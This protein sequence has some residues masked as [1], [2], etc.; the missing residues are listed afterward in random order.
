MTKPVIEHIGETNTDALTRSGQAAEHLVEN[1]AAAATKSGQTAQRIMK[2]NID[3][4]TKSGNASGAAFKEL[5]AAYQELATK[6]VK[7]LTAAMQALA[8][9]KHPAEFVTLQQR[10]IKDGVEAAVRDGQHIAQLTAAVF[11]A[12]FQPVKHRIEAVQ[13]KAVD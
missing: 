13:K 2:Y 12:A 7:N 5:T 10:L 11:T 6:N 8:T 9:V 4:L 1:G 3:A